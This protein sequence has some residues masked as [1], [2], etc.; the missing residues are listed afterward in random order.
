MPFGSSQWMYSS[1][2][3]PTVIDQS[4]RFDGS[5][6]LSRTPSV[7][8]NRTTWTFSTWVKRGNLGTSQMLFSASTGTV[9]YVTIQSDDTIRWRNS[10]LDYET[11]PV[12]R[13]SS[14][15]Y[16]LVFKWDTTNGTAADR[17]IIYV[18]GEQVTAYDIKTNASSSENS[19]WNNNEIQNIGRYAATGT[20]NYDG[21]L[22]D[23]YS[24][25]GTALDPT[26]FG[27]FKNGVWIPKAYTGSY[28][29]NGFH[30]EYDGNTND[31]SGTGNNWT[32]TN[33]VAGDYMLDSPTDNFCTLNPLVRRRDETDIPTYSEGNLKAVHPDAGGN[34]TYGVGTISVSSGKWYFECYQVDEATNILVGIADRQYDEAVNS[35]IGYFSDDGG[36]YRYGTLVTTGDTFTT[37]DTIGIAFDLDASTMTCYKNGV[38]QGTISGTWSNTHSPTPFI[39][40]N[41][42]NSYVMN[43]GQSGFT[44]TP[45]DGFLALC[46]ANLPE[47]SISPLY[48]ASPQDHFNT[49]LY[50]GNDVSNAVTGVG[51]QP[52]FVWMKNRASTYYHGLYDVVRGTGTSKSLYS[53]TTEAEGTNSTNQNLVSFDSDGFTLGLTSST[54]VINTNGEAHVA[55]NWKASNATAVSNTEGTITSQVS[56]NP[57]AGFSI[58]SYTGNG[59]NGATIGHGLGA[60]PTMIITKKRNSALGWYVW[61][62]QLSGANYGVALN[63]TDAEGTF[64]YG[65]WGTKN[66][67]IITATQ[68]T[69]GLTNVNASSDTYVAYCFA[70]VE[71][72]S[73]FGSYTG[74]GSSDGPFAYTGFRPAFVMIK[75]TDS[76]GAWQMYDTSRAST[77]VM[78]TTLAADL[79]SAESAFTGGYDIDFVS[80]G[81]KPR[82]GPSNAINT[83]SG[84]YIYMAFAENPFKYANAR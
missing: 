77:N 10:T 14:A 20:F 31:S 78:T 83:S 59:T 35:L 54:N 52:D 67:T 36:L 64:S 60:T 76:T 46:T 44:Y 84:T 39:Q 25:D 47:P 49:V 41:T 69:N 27:E 4:L 82:T 5:S 75:R 22:A 61:H 71:G 40:A 19:A 16:H 65:T 1:G 73:K 42:S 6:Y 9:H 30:L 37:G 13:D 66:S 29:T 15:W 8:G 79:S 33:I 68:G 72:Y 24:I 12:F 11:T 7:A 53:N 62:Q 32:A 51:F 50:T 74:N 23:T 38:S 43:F 80:N 26:S 63:T 45:P 21:Y 28:G 56:A 34:A 81:F 58:V 3:Y 2:F 70:D 55:W 18:N 48:G 57:T 17:A